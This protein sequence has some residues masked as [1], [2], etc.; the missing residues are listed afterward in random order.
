[1]LSV[2]GFS[3]GHIISI[4]GLSLLVIGVYLF[5]PKS[6]VQQD[7]PITLSALSEAVPLKLESA[8]QIDTVPLPLAPILSSKAWIVGEKETPANDLIVPSTILDAVLIEQAKGGT[9]ERSLT[10]WLTAKSI[11]QSPSWQRVFD[12]LKNPPKDHYTL[13]LARL[14]SLNLAWQWI[15]QHRLPSALIYPNIDVKKAEFIVILGDFSTKQEA[16]Q[17]EEKLNRQFESLKIDLR[18]YAQIQK[19]LANVKKIIDKA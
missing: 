6:P 19:A 15:S 11:M 4:G 8:I 16:L 13:Q 12:V 7:V 1:M 10:P 14:P 2:N 3:R 5:F 17:I 9:G 18:T